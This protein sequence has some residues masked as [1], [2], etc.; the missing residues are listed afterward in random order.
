MKKI[1]VILLVVLCLMGCTAETFEKVED[2]LVQQV[3]HPQKK[4]NIAL[5]DGVIAIHSGENTI[6]LCDGYEVTVQT[7]SSGNL[8]ATLKEITG[9]EKEELTVYM[10]KEDDLDRYECAWA[11]AGENGDVTGRAV[12]YDD[13]SHHYCVTV[14]ADANDAQALLPAWNEILDSVTFS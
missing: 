11:S 6:Y 8:S 3:M 4:V 7:H 14:M 5:E 13:G 10:T 12:V 9:F 1:V 2:E